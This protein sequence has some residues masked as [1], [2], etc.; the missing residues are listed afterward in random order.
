[1]FTEVQLNIPLPLLER[2]LGTIL[3]LSPVAIR[4][5]G[6]QNS[7]DKAFSEWEVNL[8]REIYVSIGRSSRLYF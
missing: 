5:F 4:S 8:F 6:L 7:L 2:I 1:M 3:L